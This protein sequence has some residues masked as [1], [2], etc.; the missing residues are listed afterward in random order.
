M[1]TLFEYTII[2][3]NSPLLLGASAISNILLLKNYATVLNLMYMLFGTCGGVSSEC[4]SKSRISRHRV[5]EY[6]DLLD[7]VKF[8]SSSYILH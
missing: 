5:S 7:L 6:A 1:T 3:S 2:Y 4:M 8:A